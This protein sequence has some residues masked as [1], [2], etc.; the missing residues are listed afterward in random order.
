MGEGKALRVGGVA[1]LERGVAT[2]LWRCVALTWW[3]RV[4][5]VLWR[6]VALWRGVAPTAGRRALHKIQLRA[7]NIVKL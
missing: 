5:L 2:T 7:T 4:A 6:R 3:R 1:L